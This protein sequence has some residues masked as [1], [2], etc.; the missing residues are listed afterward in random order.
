MKY[1][2]VFF[3]ILS[4]S[5]CSNIITDSQNSTNED[6]VLFYV[7]DN[8]SDSISVYTI[9]SD[10]S[11]QKLIEKGERRYPAW[12]E[13][14]SKIITIKR[15]M[16]SEHSRYQYDL[17]LLSLSDDDLLFQTLEADV[18]NISFLKYS[19]TL[20]S[21]LYS[22][23][24]YGISRIGRINLQSK[25]ITKYNTRQY[26]ERNPVCSEVDD[27]IYFS[28]KR[29][30]TFDIYK[31]KKDG[32]E[33]Q[34]VIIDQVFDLTTFSVSTDGEL[35]VASRYNDQYSYL[36]V[37]NLDNNEIIQNIDA[38]EF[39]MAL[40]PSFTKDNKRILFNNG[41]PYDY[42]TTRNIHIMNIDG[43]NYKQLTFFENF[44]TARPLA[45]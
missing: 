28:T 34:P 11:Q 7:I 37:Y 27:W 31:M 4:F 8:D 5:S 16:D 38:S 41:I 44:L 36:T 32:S 14:P 21:I 3:V 15:F 20:N 33:Y 10:G 30:T 39:S 9:L 19:Q 26:D 40:Y 23:S 1:L 12:Y 24:D 22:F 13:Y 25:N 35:L 45:W 29:D 43:S 42:S 2:I 18:E 6:L 17:D